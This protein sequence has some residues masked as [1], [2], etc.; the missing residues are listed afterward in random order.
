RRFVAVNA[1][2]MYAWQLNWRGENFYSGG[3]IWNPPFE[4]MKTVFVDVDTT[5]FSS[6][7]KPQVGSGKSYFL[8]TEI[9]RVKKLRELLMGLAPDARLEEVDRSNNKYGMVKFSL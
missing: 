3:E 4:D 2:R 9:E 1:D 6:W 8:I 7:L 5:K